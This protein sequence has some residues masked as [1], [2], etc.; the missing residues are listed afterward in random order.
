MQDDIKTFRQQEAVRGIVLGFIPF[1]A[2]PS[3]TATT[4]T[5]AALD[6][7]KEL[8][9]AI[10]IHM[11]LMFDNGCKLTLCLPHLSTR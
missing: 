8:A 4:D 2:N 1:L 6:P 5:S 9:P 7:M 3:Q 11:S 10:K